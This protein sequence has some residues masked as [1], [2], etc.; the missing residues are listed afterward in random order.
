MSSDGLLKDSKN[1][2]KN[3]VIIGGGAAGMVCILSTLS[4]AVPY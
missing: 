2:K 1:G 4:Y 3:V